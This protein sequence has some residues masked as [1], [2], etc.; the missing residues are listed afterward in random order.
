M[1]TNYSPRLPYPQD[2]I[3]LIDAANSKH[4]TGSGNIFDAKSS[5]V[6]A[7]GQTVTNTTTDNIQTFDMN[8]GYLE[9]P[10]SFTFGQ[11]YTCFYLWKPKANASSWKTLHRNNFDHLALVSS[12]DKVSIGVYSNRNGNF[13][14]SGYDIT[15]DV[16]QSLIFTGEGTSPT[17]T[18]GTT[19]FYV[20]GV[21]V[22]TS[23]RVGCGTSLYRIGWAS[24]P[25]G[26]IAIAGSYNRLLNANEISDLN[27]VLLGRLNGS[28]T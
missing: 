24:Q 7:R 23:D 27:T 6:W 3:N 18:T 28:S 21:S 14:D 15:N 11:Y 12:G 1:A 9:T 5:I 8:N 20:N 2:L 25:P 13:R 22:G 4:T 17:A 19:T 10:D 16:W 26:Y